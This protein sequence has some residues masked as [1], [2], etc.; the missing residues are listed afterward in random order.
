MITG[1]ILLIY[2][3]AITTKGSAT[4]N[5]TKCILTAVLACN[6]SNNSYVTSAM[7]YRILR[8]AEENEL[9]LYKT[10][11]VFAESGILYSITSFALFI[12]MASWKGQGRGVLLCDA[13]NFST[14]GIAFN[15]IL[16]RSARYRARQ[17]TMGDMPKEKHS[18]NSHG[19]DLLLEPTITE[20]N[21]G[22]IS[23]Q[24]TV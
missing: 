19:E 20:E 15:L 3:N 21:W 16:I 8:M 18:S 10:C 24:P 14:A 5:I 4:E 11:R 7:T 9:Y 1:M 22:E 23:L 6:F 2:W 17:R 12:A 13:I